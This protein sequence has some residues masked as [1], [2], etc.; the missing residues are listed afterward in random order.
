MTSQQWAETDFR[1]VIGRTCI[2]YDQKKEQ[3]NRNKH[4]YSL[5]SAVYLLQ[6]LILPIPSP[7]FITTAPFEEKGEVRHNHMTRDDNGQVLF[8]VTTM[9]P[10]ETVRVISLR[11]ASADEKSLY[12]EL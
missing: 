6:R 4:K 10:R 3:T 11:L 9:R 1:V 12:V 7:L 8:F 5:E 2:D